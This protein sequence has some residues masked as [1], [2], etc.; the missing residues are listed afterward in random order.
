MLSGTIKKRESI[1]PETIKNDLKATRAGQTWSGVEK[2]ATNN[3][4][5]IV[6]SHDALRLPA[7]RL[8]ANS[9]LCVNL[10]LEILGLRIRLLLGVTT[11]I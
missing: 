3:K 1:V 7:A 6:L 11:L 10:A 9:R 4:P 2:N 5:A 8:L